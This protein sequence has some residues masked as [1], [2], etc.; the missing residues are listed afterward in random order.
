MKTIRIK[1]TIILT[2]VISLIAYSQTGEDDKIRI[3]PVNGYLVLAGGGGLCDSI[4]KRFIDLAGGQDAPIVVIPTADGRETHGIDAAGAGTMR[5]LGA[6]NITILHT[7]QKNIANTDSF[8]SPLLEAKGVWFGGGRQWRLVDAYKDT[9]T[10]KMFWNVLERGG[11]IG[12]TSAGAT[13]QGSFLAR[14]DTKNNQIMMGDHEEGFG[15]IK[16]IAIDQHALARNRQFDMFQILKNRPDLLGIG[17]DENTAI[18]V[19]GDSFE[20]IGNSYILIYDGSFWSREGWDLK[21]LPESN[22]LFYFLREG[23][24]YNLAERKIAD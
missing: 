1:T 22:R 23:D 12:G 11:V 10:E 20:V 18:I 9:K 2:L 5:K 19:E 16:K 3:G 14:G 4:F 8:V 15:F 13:I 17:I 24:K 7:T 6:K 21:K